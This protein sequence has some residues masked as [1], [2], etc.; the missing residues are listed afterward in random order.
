MTPLLEFERRARL[1]PVRAEREDRPPS[2][3]SAFLISEAAHC[4]HLDTLPPHELNRRCVLGNARVEVA[5]RLSLPDRVHTLSAHLKPHPSVLVAA[6]RA[7]LSACF[8]RFAQPRPQCHLKRRTL[9]LLQLSA[10]QSHTGNSSAA[11]CEESQ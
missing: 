7:Y 8:D 2:V 6:V 4:G 1:E 10:K 9:P 3:T 5:E 11:P